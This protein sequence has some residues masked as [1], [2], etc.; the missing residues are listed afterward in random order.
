MTT[1][2]Q[3][4][5]RPAHEK[6]MSFAEWLQEGATHAAKPT[7]APSEALWLGNGIVE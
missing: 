5:N 2:A 7:N 3:W 4:L 6:R 1:R